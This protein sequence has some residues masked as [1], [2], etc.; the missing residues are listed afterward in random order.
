MK[1]II[2]AAGRGSRMGNLTEA[3]PKC[4]TE[5]RGHA[6]LD[7]Q[8]RSLR[9]AGVSRIAIVTGYKGESLKRPGLKPFV[10]SRWEATNMVV[11]LLAAAEWLRA[12]DCLVSYG[13]IVYAPATVSAL[14]AAPGDITISSNQ[15]WLKVW[16]AR[17]ADPL[18][19]AESFAVDAEG[20]LL[21]IGRRARQLDEIQGQYMGLL[22]FTPAGWAQVEAYL[23]TLDPS[24]IDRLDMTS[25]L[26]RLLAAGIRIDTVP[27]AGGWLEIDSESDL[28]AA[29]AQ[30]QSD[31]SFDWLREAAGT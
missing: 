23:Q 12:G 29:E 20:R 11:S 22:R 19:D 10:N 27:V 9:L 4:L 21:D 31:A 25:L 16:Q 5:L 14:A 30:V 26:Q 15:D 3:Q 1:G 8:L 7:W 2:L 13:D 28:R 24:G 17:F 6:L 18:S